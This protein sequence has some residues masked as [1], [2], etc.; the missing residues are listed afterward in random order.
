MAERHSGSTGTVRTSLTAPS[1]PAGAINLTGVDFPKLP[2]AAC[3]GVTDPER[4]FAFEDHRI[5]QAREV[6]RRCPVIREC[7]AWA[8][9]HTEHGVWAATTASERTELL[10][11]H[12]RTA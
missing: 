6:C 7:L 11:R 8:L 9:T 10:A 4:F 1:S 5:E 12:R 3:K 2:D